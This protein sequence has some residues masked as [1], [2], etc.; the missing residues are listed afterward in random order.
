MRNWLIALTML[1]VVTLAGCDIYLGDAPPEVETVED[2]WVEG[3]VLH[4]QI[5][6]KT[7]EAGEV[8][9]DL[10]LREEDGAIEWRYAGEAWETLV[11][12]HALEAE[13][14]D[15]DVT[16]EEILWRR[17]DADWETLI[18]LS[19]LEGPAGE[20]GR[21][22]ELRTH[23][24]ALEWRY[25][26][27]DWSHLLDIDA[28]EVELDAGIESVYINEDYE[29]VVEF[30]DGEIDALALPFAAHRV[31]F[32]DAEG[33]V[34]DVAFAQHEET[35]DKPEPPE[36]DGLNFTGWSQ[37]TE[38]VDSDM[39][40]EA[41]YEADAFTIEYETYTDATIGDATYLYDEPVDLP[42]VEKD[43]ALFLGWYVDEDFTRLFN[44]ET[45]PAEDLT[46]HARFFTFEGTEH[47][48][49]TAFEDVLEDMHEGVVFIEVTDEDGTGSGSG[50]I[51]GRD[52]DI[53]SV[54]T[55]EHVVGDAD[56]IDVGYALDGNPFFTGAQDVELVGAH[57]GTDTALITF[58]SPHDLPILEFRPIEDV[59]IA[60]TVYAIGSPLGFDHF[61]TVTRGIVSKLHLDQ[62]YHEG[63]LLQHDASINPGN[64]GGPLV[65][66]EGRIVAMNTYYDT[67]ERNDETWRAEGM[68][69]AVPSSTM[70][71]MMLDFE[72]YGEARFT[73][74]GLS[75]VHPSDCG[76]LQGACVDDIAPASTADALGLEED[77]LIIGFKT[78]DMDDFVDI[79]NTYMLSEL[80][81]N[82]RV[83]EFIAFR[84]VRDDATHETDYQPAQEE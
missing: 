13:T 74:I 73:D 61:N 2:A 35:I 83:D 67:F 51:V 14:V 32:L 84:Y 70:E 34:F 26:D 29:F 38:T 78:E 43:D 53:Y 46:L 25:E 45:M 54:I 55:N 59:R 77:D 48:E 11:E 31:Q 72:D 22:I 40:V 5:G 63:F 8:L 16:D 21:E 60:E 36:Y 71:R 18:A 30:T 82:V 42:T 49:E 75:Y 10:E 9:H 6:D 4:L 66:E 81:F 52:G 62:A 28:L 27:G 56:E 1:L 47:E 57:E 68:F 20:D 79:D 12:E 15:L 80:L 65:D 37:S 76:A 24:E 23:E 3:G 58:E 41:E 17:N 33:R 39:S 44:D 64:S 7:I 19:E 50:A 69:Y